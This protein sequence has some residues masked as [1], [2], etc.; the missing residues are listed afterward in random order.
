MSESSLAKNKIVAFFIFILI[1]LLLGVNI[2]KNLATSETKLLL[3][4]ENDV[5][6]PSDAPIKRNGDFFYLNGNVK[7]SIV[8][9]SD[10]IIIDGKSFLLQGEGTGIGI[11]LS[12]RTNVTIQNIQIDAFQIG[13][14]LTASSSCKIIGNNI[15]SCIDWAGIYLINSS[16]NMIEFNT[17]NNNWDG[18]QLDPESS[19]N[20]IYKNTIAN[21]RNGIS[22]SF[23][24]ENNIISENKLNNNTNYGVGLFWYI[25][26]PSNIC[27]FGNQIENSKIGITISLA[28]TNRIEENSILNNELG[29][30]LSG[31]SKNIIT[32]NNLTKNG[33][34]ILLYNYTSRY[35]ECIYSENNLFEN[36]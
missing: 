26:S 15:S 31:S 5:I 10:N 16:N 13:I 36:N 3:S 11:D 25:A 33:D 23:L 30:L 17:I 22:I 32:H 6:F 34:C 14:H 24:S 19:D 28:S 7:G 12:G 21:N 27:I 20:N 35:G 2:T 8:V 9:K 18:I 29:I 1:F 4:P